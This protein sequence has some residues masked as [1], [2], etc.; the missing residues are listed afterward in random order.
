MEEKVNY[1]AKVLL[2]LLFE[3]SRHFVF[4]MASVE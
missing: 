2:R 3:G 1:K 4:E